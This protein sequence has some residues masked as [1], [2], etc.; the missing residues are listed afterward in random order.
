MKS[1]Y[2]YNAKELN[3][4][5]RTTDKV[6]EDIISK[7]LS[8]YEMDE[9]DKL[10]RMIPSHIKNNDFPDFLSKDLDQLGSLPNWI[11][12][13][14]IKNAQ[15]I[16]W[17]YGREILLALLFRSL[18]MC[19]ICANG[20]KVLKITGRLIDKNDNPNYERRL[21]ETLQFV[22][23]I[24]SEE[25]GF[26]KNGLALT[27]IKRVR[28]IHAT[29]RRYIHENIEWPSEERGEPINMEDELIT[30]SAFSIEVI[31]A[32]SHMGIYLSES[33]KN[34]W[35]HLWACTGYLLGIEEKL[36]PKG[37]NECLEMRNN[38]LSTQMK[39]SVA[40]NELVLS[41]VTFMTDLLPLKI[42]HSLSYATMKYLNDEPYRT[43]M[44]LNQK[45]WFWDW[46]IPKIMNKTLGIDQRL[47]KKSPIWLFIIKKTNHWLLTE[48]VKKKFP[49]GSYFYLPKSLKN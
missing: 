1:N 24:C 11:D 25:T 34:D 31:H 29:I 32:L 12:H 8:H 33:E 40:G 47:E 5:R 39:P 2:P 48:L 19:Y 7:L 44:G 17:S 6:G 49:H 3:A 23:N 36:L 37:Y 13:Q 43:V 21:L 38:I 35:C 27:T 26:E 15:N 18:P 42:L 9:I 46:A 14:K 10:F 28:L 45:H 16:F 41:C 20:A 30:I 4:F 22:I